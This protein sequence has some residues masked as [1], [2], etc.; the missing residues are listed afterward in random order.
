MRQVFGPA[1]NLPFFIVFE[2]LLTYAKQLITLMP[3]KA[4]FHVQRLYGFLAP[5]TVA[6]PPLWRKS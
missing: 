5:R 2:T 6:P 1:G 3:D 4:F